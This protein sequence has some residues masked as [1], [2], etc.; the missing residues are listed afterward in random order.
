[1]A[2]SANLESCPSRKWIANDFPPMSQLNKLLILL[3]LL[4]PCAP[5]VRTN[6]EG[7]NS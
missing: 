7:E 5:H 6:V 2:V 3:I 1:M 4:L